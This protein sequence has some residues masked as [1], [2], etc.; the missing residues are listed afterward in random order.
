M[1]VE[2]SQE[3]AKPVTTVQDCVLTSV[4]MKW[5]FCKMTCGHV[6]LR[7][8]QQYLYFKLKHVLF[9]TI[10]QVLFVSKPNQ[11]TTTALS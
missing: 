1:V 11:N 10:T 8:W 2:F 5:I 7:L 3:A 9:I 6:W 4:S